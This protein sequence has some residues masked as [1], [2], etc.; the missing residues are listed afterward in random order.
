MA[1]PLAA[2]VCKLS[3]NP[4][5][6]CLPRRFRATQISRHGYLIQI[7]FMMRIDDPVSKF[8]LGLNDFDV[9]SCKGREELVVFP[10]SKSEVH[11]V[12]F[13]LFVKW[14]LGMQTLTKGH[15]PQFTTLG[16]ETRKAFI[17]QKMKGKQRSS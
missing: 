5:Q 6:I 10:M 7:I 13:E 9:H 14:A 2:G 4:L 11:E 17:I 15:Y 16:H 3:L 1:G 8:S 12:S